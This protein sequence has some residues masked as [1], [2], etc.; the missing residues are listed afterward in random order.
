LVWC[1]A[2]VGAFAEGITCGEEGVRVAEAVE[3]PFSRIQAYYSVGLL[4]LR[5]GEYPRAIAALARD[6]EL[7]QTWD[8]QLWFPRIASTLGTAFALSGRLADALPL[9]EQAV[10]RAAA[11][12]Q[13]FGHSLWAAGLSEAYLLA[14]RREEAVPLAQ[15]SLER[16]RAHQER[17]NQAWA[18]RLL[19]EIHAHCDP[20]EVEPAEAC[21]HQALALADGLGMRPLVA[22]CHLGL[23]TLYLK[24][25]RQ[26]P[27]YTELSAAIGLYR[28]MEM[29]FWLPQA[30]AALAQ[31]EGR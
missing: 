10:E 6:L 19:G 31:V 27:A 8:V 15:R 7:C 29:T 12:R 24:I 9:L 26:N 3:H 22:H 4:Y 1:L 21:F 5:K 30:E 28:A 18:L 16:F 25:G 14:G 17:G 11:M 23:G 13:T 2:E 20:P